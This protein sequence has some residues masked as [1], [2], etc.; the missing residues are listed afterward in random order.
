MRRSLFSSCRSFPT[1]RWRFAKCAAGVLLGDVLP[2]VMGRLFGPRLLRLRWMRLV[3]NKGRLATFDRW[4]RRRGD[5]VILIARFIPGLR[6]VAFFTGGTMRM[7][8]SRFLILD[9]CG[10]LLSAPTFV[11]IGWHFGDKIQEAYHWVG[12]VEDSI[13]ALLVVGGGVLGMWYWMRRRA[14]RRRLVAGPR[15]TFVEQRRPSHR[16]PVEGEPSS[17]PAPADAGEVGDQ[18]ARRDEGPPN[19]R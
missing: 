2:F 13:L 8:W 19:A 4:F 6:V 18:S 5:A 16:E 17:P 7:P 1:R 11:F 10:I 12:Q 3:I 15:E 9:T 14:G